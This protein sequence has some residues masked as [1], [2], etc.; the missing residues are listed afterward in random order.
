M[1]VLLFFLAATSV[2]SSVILHQ[3]L[4]TRVQTRLQE[5][6]SETARLLTELRFANITA[7]CFQLAGAISLSISAVLEEGCS[8]LLLR[9][10]LL[11]SFK[12]G[13]TKSLTKIGVHDCEFD[14]YFRTLLQKH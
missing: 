5:F 14:G 10:V 4:K 6:N 1:S 12:L 7:T 2:S 13:S 8:E 3:C 9:I 11:V